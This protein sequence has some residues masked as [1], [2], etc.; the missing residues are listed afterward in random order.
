MPLVK[1]KA[2]HTLAFWVFSFLGGASA[3]YAAPFEAPTLEDPS[4][5]VHLGWL[6]GGSRSLSGAQT[7]SV[8]IEKSPTES[9]ELIFQQPRTVTMN[10]TRQWVNFQY[11]IPRDVLRWQ[12]Y[13]KYEVLF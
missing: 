13:P 3:A 7:I 6:S 8:P 10:G 4:R 2:Q 5:S 12:Q 1:R 9:V 11:A